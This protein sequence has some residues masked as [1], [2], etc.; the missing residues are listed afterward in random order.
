MQGQEFADNYMLEY[1]RV[2]GGTWTRFKD[3]KRNEVCLEQGRGGGGWERCVLDDCVASA[4][5]Y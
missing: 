5:S 1:M 2:D 3:K 4:L